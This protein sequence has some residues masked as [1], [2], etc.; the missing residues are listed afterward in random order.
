MHIIFLIANNSYV[1]YFNW[2]AEEAA[3]QPEVKFSFV[4]LY[5]ERPR[6]LDDMTMREADC[7]WIPYNPEK[8]KRQLP[9]LVVKLYR[10]FR[11]LKPD[12][13]HS[14]LF[15]DS[16]VSLIAG[17]LAGV[18][19]R[20]ITKQDTGFHWNYTP[21][22][23][24]FDRLNNRL[25]THI[26]TVA[27]ENTKFV[28]E[29]ER[30]PKEKI[31]LI[32]NGFPF[33]L[34][35]NSSEETISGL[36]SKYQLHG[37]FVIGTVARF[38]EWKG[39]KLIIEAAEQL[40]R[41]HPDIVFIWAG[42]GKKEY[43]DELF[44]KVKSKG[45]SNNVIYASWIEREWMPSFYRC[46]DMY[47]HPAIEEPFGFAI[48]EAMMNAVPVAAT[49]TGST[50]LVRHKKEGFILRSGSVDDIIESVRLFYNDPGLRASIAAAGQAH[51]KEHLIFQRMFEEHMEMYR[52]AM[53]EQ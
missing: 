28:I 20:V 44:S 29:K 48:T 4:A 40:I 18:K 27:D 32:R 26:H 2:F 41:D 22:Y 46:M 14:H 52:K 7:Y 43:I 33:E 30:A 39:H 23:V 42:Y 49:K 38:I 19:V 47:L 31:H 34:M 21:Q 9:G 1:P 6:M 3:K 10:L 25:A 45:L 5:H 24:R 12:I 36:K 11:K 37:R 35:T 53:R 51:A 50:D 8:R 16:L 13:I 15:D 17:K